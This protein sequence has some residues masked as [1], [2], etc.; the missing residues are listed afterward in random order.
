MKFKFK[1]NNRR[2]G[3]FESFYLSENDRLQF[4]RS[5]LI[6]AIKSFDVDVNIVWDGRVSRRRKNWK[7]NW[8]VGGSSNIPS[9][10]SI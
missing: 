7:K 3:N 1:G 9:S 10:S 4:I 8:Q 6:K 2:E 5:L